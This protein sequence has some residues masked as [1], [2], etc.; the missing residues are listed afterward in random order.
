MLVYAARRCCTGQIRR[1]EHR[2]FECNRA[3][4][5]RRRVR[6]R[7]FRRRLPS[8]NS[9]RPSASPRSPSAARARSRNLTGVSPG[10]PAVRRG[11]CGSGSTSCPS[12]RSALSPATP[13]GPSRSA[14]PI[15]AA[16]GRT[17]R[18]HLAASESS[19]SPLCPEI[20]NFKLDEYRPSRRT[21]VAAQ[22]CPHFGHNRTLKWTLKANSPLS[23]ARNLLI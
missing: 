2:R 23:D 8:G 14:H 16:C 9:C 4:A 18:L 1:S 6:L 15:D 20:R 11:S 5:S 21:H 3:T 13:S 22:Q 7:I 10:P 17:L 12:P 19:K